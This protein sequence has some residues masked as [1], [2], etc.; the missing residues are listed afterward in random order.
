[1]K[2][3]IIEDDIAFANALARRLKRYNFDTRIV[4]AEVDIQSQCQ[5]WCP[6]FVLLDMNLDGVSGLNFIPMIR[7]LRPKCRLVL[8]TGFASIATAVQAV[9]L[10]AD[11]Y[12]SKPADSTLVAQTLLGQKLSTTY[13]PSTELMSADRLEWEHI[14]Q[15]LKANDGNV[16]QTARQLNMHRRTLQR[17]L[18]KRPAHK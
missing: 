5:Q 8:L 11:D 17:K 15:A 1:M 7:K 3:L 6:D 2:L 14:Q 13:E 10:G 18:Q 16:S 4:S 9:K 12:L